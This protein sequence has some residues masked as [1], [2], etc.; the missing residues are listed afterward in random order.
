MDSEAGASSWCR[1]PAV[2]SQV[3]VVPLQA[4]GLGLRFGGASEGVMVASAG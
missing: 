1:L 3:T 4:H 2:K